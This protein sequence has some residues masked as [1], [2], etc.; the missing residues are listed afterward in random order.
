MVFVVSQKHQEFP[1]RWEQEVIN[2]GTIDGF[3][4]VHSDDAP[5]D[6]CVFTTSNGFDRFVCKLEKKESA[7]K[8]I[9][10]IMRTHVNNE[11]HIVNDISELFISEIK[12]ILDQNTMLEIMFSVLEKHGYGELVDQFYELEKSDENAEG[13]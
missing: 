13:E 6:V 3:K 10:Q 1:G 12:D 7:S 2:I 5:E 9:E 8:L 4:L 11:A